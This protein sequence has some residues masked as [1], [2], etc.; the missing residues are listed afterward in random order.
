MNEVNYIV[1]GEVME[2]Y[3]YELYG[4][5]EDQGLLTDCENGI[6]QFPY[7][8]EKIEQLVVSIRQ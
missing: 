2:E 6:P 5:N 4:F 1:F 7:V 8:K 3:H